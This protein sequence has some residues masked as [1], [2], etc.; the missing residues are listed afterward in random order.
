MIE[1]PRYSIKNLDPLH[2]SPDIFKKKS[3]NRS[4]TEKDHNHLWSKYRSGHQ[5]PIYN[6][7]YGQSYPSTILSIVK[8]ASDYNLSPIIQQP[9]LFFFQKQIRRVYSFPKWENDYKIWNNAANIV[10]SIFNLYFSYIRS[11]K[12]NQYVLHCS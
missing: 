5:S 2:P 6:T 7:I 4:V 1:T 3:A 11:F 12:L 8:K 10:G 9:A